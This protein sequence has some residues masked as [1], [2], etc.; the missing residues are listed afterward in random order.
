MTKIRRI[1]AVVILCLVVLLVG[2]SCYTGS[3]L[4]N[5]PQ[6]LDDYK[7]MAFYGKGGSIVAFTDGY[8]WYQ[9]EEQKII[10]LQI[11][12]Y[13]QGVIIMARNDI[14][15]YFTAI[16]GDTLYD[17]QTQEFLTRRGADG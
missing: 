15:F 14:K 3:R 1:L 6:T 17:E 16:D 8:A 11:T 5:A 13:K 7:N 4:T 10:L 12:E 2:Y 9:T